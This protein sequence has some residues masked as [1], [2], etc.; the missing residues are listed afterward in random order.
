VITATDEPA[1]RGPLDR[2]VMRPIRP[3]DAQRLVRF[4]AS[5]SPE[6]TRL[7]FFGAHPRLTEREVARFTT[8]DRHDRDALVV[9]AGDEIVAVARFDREGAGDRAEVAFVVTDAWQG[10]G[11]GA[12]L[13]RGIAAQAHRQGIRRLVALVLPENRPMLDLLQHTGLPGTRR[14]EDGAIHVELDL[15]A[16]APASWTTGRRPRG[17]IPGG[18]GREG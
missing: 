3:S 4:H 12:A 15:D 5:L 1:R 7:R 14:F 17:D 13:F 2:L 8:V 10:R 9:L 16:R 6:T 18:D 11:L